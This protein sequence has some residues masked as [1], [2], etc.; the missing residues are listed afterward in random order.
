MHGGPVRLRPVRATP[1]FEVE[2]WH[3]YDEKE[4][5]V[6]DKKAFRACIYSDELDRLLEAEAWQSYVAVSTWFIKSKANSN[7]NSNTKVDNKRMHG[8]DQNA[9]LRTQQ[10]ATSHAGLELPPGMPGISRALVTVVPGTAL[11]KNIPAGDTI[12]PAEAVLSDCLTTAKA[13]EIPPNCM[14]AN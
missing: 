7:M 8:S 5:D 10:L 2:L 9:G 11:A 6:R 14:L 4:G 13:I 1:C 3:R 12:I